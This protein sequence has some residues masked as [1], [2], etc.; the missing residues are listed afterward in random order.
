MT[1]SWLGPVKQISYTTD[2]VDRMVEFW[3]NQVGI[4]PWSI[5]RGLTLTMTFEGR[6]IALPVNVGLTVHGG[7]L[8]EL[9]QVMGNGPSPFHDNLNRPIIGL[10]R[11][12]AATDHIE[13]D[14]KAAVERG[15]E[16]FAS[17]RDATGQRYT[18]FRSPLAPGVILEDRKSVV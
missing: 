18:Y 13:A 9:M 16:M 11:L 3:E 7:V 10:Q 17:G 15:M 5:F 12:A 14:N 1:A 4:G 8:I 2:N 6:Q